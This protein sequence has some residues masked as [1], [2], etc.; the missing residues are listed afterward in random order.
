MGAGWDAS[1]EG[2]ACAV[3]PYG[4]LTK[5][6]ALAELSAL[7]LEWLRLGIGYNFSPISTVGVVCDEPGQRGV[8]VRAEAVY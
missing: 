4:E 8:F 6:G 1:L 2:R 3:P 5:Y 7:T